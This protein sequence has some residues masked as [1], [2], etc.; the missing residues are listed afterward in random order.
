ME[1][2]SGDYGNYYKSFSWH[3]FIQNL[4]IGPGGHKKRYYRYKTKI[5]L[6]VAQ[7]NLKYANTDANS[8]ERGGIPGARNSER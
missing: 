2:I 8:L 7:A 5:N 1:P 4:M 6:N 3:I